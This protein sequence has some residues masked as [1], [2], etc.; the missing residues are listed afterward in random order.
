MSRCCT[1]IAPASAIVICYWLCR[2]Y[3]FLSDYETAV[4]YFVDLLAGGRSGT[5]QLRRQARH[6]QSVDRQSTFLREFLFVV[7]VRCW[8]LVWAKI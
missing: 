5:E 3:C 7:K 6:Q 2:D 8:G 1:R 4:R